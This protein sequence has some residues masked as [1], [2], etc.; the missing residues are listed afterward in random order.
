MNFEGLFL[1]DILLQKLRYDFN[2][3]HDLDL[4][5]FPLRGPYPIY[6]I[7]KGDAQFVRADVMM[8]MIR[9]SSSG[10]NEIS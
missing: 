3:D 10:H 1:D 7:G 5:K 8:M 6:Y 2:V 4:G 9:A